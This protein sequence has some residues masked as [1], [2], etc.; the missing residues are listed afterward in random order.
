M[1]EKSRMKTALKGVEKIL[2]ERDRIKSVIA[3]EVGKLTPL[4]Q[5]RLDAE[6]DLAA[7]EADANAERVTKKIRPSPPRSAAQL[8]LSVLESPHM[9]IFF[10]QPDG[11]LEHNRCVLE[12]RRVC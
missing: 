9:K 7:A 5:V 4:I 6:N 2:T 11:Y 8:G 10:N 12:R 1:F 3:T